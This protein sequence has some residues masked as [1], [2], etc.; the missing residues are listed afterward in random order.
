[1]RWK[2]CGALGL[3]VLAVV[4]AGCGS[5]SDDSGG[6]GASASASTGGKKLSGPP[7]KV[8]VSAPINAPAYAYPQIY[9]TVQAGIDGINRRGGIKGSKIV[10][11]KCDNGNDPN[12][13]AQCAQQ[14]VKEG[15]IALVGP[16][17]LI[18]GAGFYPVIEAA[19]IPMVGNGP[20]VPQDWTSKYAFPV[21]YSPQAYVAGPPVAM[22]RE[23]C[24]KITTTGFEDKAYD[25]YFA[26]A[27]AGIA[28]AKAQF[29]GEARFAANATDFTPV[30]QKAIGQGAD[31]IMT[32]GPDQATA[33]LL[34]AIKTSGKDLK[35]GGLTHI[36]DPLP[37]LGKQ[38]DGSPLAAPHPD[39]TLD[40]APDAPALMKRYADDMKADSFTDPKELVLQGF[41]QWLGTQLFEQAANTIPAGKVTK[42]TLFDA[43]NKTVFDPVGV[44][45]KSDFTQPSPVKAT[46]RMS[47]YTMFLKVVKDGK[48]VL[49]SGENPV[50]LTRLF[51]GLQK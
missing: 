12:K 44:A 47:N 39:P 11:S 22:A 3:C 10:L 49:L 31:C 32:L 23:G 40:P 2:S 26:F 21:A 45:G 7:I 29:A 20:T 34:R 37:E 33:P 8:M 30:V 27:K 18:G 42:E 1:M 46:P 17:A 4:G 14:A 19:K 28:Y 9:D 41:S 24:K 51:E 36:S 38:L 48:A 5:S 13:A 35:L 50:D 15:D 16:Y 25:P 6:G 43:L